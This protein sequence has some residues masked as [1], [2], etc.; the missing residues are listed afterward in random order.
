M[1]D[2]CVIAG[3]L[4]CSPAPSKQTLHTKRIGST[5][6]WYLWCQLSA[7]VLVAAIQDRRYPEQIAAR[8]PLGQ[9]LLS[10]TPRI[11][12]LGHAMGCFLEMVTIFLNPGGGI[13]SSLR[14]VIPKHKKAKNTASCFTR[15]GIAP[16]RVRPEHYRNGTLVAPFAALRHV[17]DNVDERSK[18]V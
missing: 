8:H 6:A 1:P 4:F 13:T 5:H 11:R 17:V 2:V 10:A 15:N 18:N 14:R 7:S 3:Q 12:T 9:Q 16:L